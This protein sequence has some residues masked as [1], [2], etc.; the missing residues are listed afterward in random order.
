[1]RRIPIAAAAHAVMDQLA[2]NPVTIG[3]PPERITFETLNI[4]MTQTSSLWD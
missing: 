1:M 2:A 3:I 4:H